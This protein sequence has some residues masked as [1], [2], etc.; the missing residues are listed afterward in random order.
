[1][2]LDRL[3]H[4]LL[5]IWS[6][7]VFLFMLAPVAV[8]VLLAFNPSRFGT[9]PITG[10]TM[11]WFAVLFADDA[12][13]KSLRTSLLLAA[14]SSVVATIA[15]VGAAYVLARYRFRLHGM[16]EMILTLPL[17]VPHLVI[18]VSMLLAL[19]LFG[20]QKSFL[21]LLLG[22]VALIMPFVIITSRH[23]LASIPKTLEEASW[24]LGATRL[25]TIREIVIPLAL[26]AILIG[27]LFAFMHSF[28]EVTA[29][30]FWRPPNT[31]TLQTQ[32][33]LMLQHEID[34]TVNALAALLVMFSVSVPVVGMMISK[35]T[36]RK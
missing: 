32:V 26:P 21:T 30:L 20:L 36:R 22:H 5:G 33:V 24:T 4:V 3:P 9:F 7:L 15:G 19:R 6:L 11:H 8:V 10:L 14:L 31:E 28:D 34:Q 2:K 23:K 18:G 29:T 27:F 35:L 1:M 17:L 25:Q 13:L 16:V 12:F